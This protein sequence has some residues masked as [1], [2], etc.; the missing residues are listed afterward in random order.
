MTSDLNQLQKQFWSGLKQFADQANSHLKFAKNPHGYWWN[1]SLGSSKC[2]I[3]L[4]LNSQKNY[5]GCEIYIPEDKSVFRKLVSKKDEIENDL[6]EEL[7][8]Q[9][10]PNAIASRIILTYDANSKDRSK[11]VEYYEW[12]IATAEDFFEVFSKYV[13]DVNKS[14]NTIKRF[15]D[16]GERKYTYVDAAQLILKDNGNRPMTVREIWDQIAD[17][18]LVKYSGSTPWSSLSSKIGGCCID[19][20]H[21]KKYG[22]IFRIASENPRKYVLI[23]DSHIIH[24]EDYETDLDRQVSDEPVL[25]RFATAL[26]VIGD[27]GAGKSTLIDSLL[28][29]ENH[30]FEFIIP[31]ATTTSLLAQ[32]QPSKSKYVISRLGKLILEAVDNPQKEY[33]AVFD[34]MHKSI[35]IE[36]VNDELLQ[37]I[38]LERNEG[39]RFISVDGEIASLYKDKLDNLNI[40]QNFGFIFITSNPKIL[41]NNPDL[42]R[43]VRVVRINKGD[44]SKINTIDDL[45][46]L[47]VLGKDYEP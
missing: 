34:E 26:L 41:K 2:H 43:R 47:S 28:E 3:C 36:M 46:N 18:N 40:P 22:A 45:L 44:S 24:V 30:E 9:E 6:G 35:V 38:S 33:T 16:F 5:I 20:G 27:S 11:W 10:L 8:W 39:R 15:D 32:F 29:K 7:T 14:K 17:R 4:T 37:A 23:D 13:T 1:I 12:M 25:N 19:S 31:T 42:I 21:R